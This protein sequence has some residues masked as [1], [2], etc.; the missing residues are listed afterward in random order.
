MRA[1]LE[2]VERRADPPG[3]FTLESV[4][5]SLKHWEFGQT[6][7]PA[8]WLTLMAWCTIKRMTE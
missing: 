2:I 8:H 6:K 3:C 1:M 7:A 4:W 5:I